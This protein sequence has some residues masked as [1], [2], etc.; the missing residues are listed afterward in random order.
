MVGS[1]PDDEFK[2]TD[3]RRRTGEASQPPAAESSVPGSSASNRLEA[4]E[5]A[6]RRPEPSLEILFMMLGTSALVA[7]GAAPDPTTGQRRPDLAAAAE[8]IDLLVLLRDKTEGNRTAEE[9]QILGDLIGDLQLR[10]VAATK[11]SG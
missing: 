6:G 5:G 1:G 4:I 7:L 9:T 3:R 8:T 2:V 11:R 10:Y